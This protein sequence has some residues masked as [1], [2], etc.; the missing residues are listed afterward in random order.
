MVIRLLRSVLPLLFFVLMAFVSENTVAQ[1]R[2]PVLEYATG[3]WCQYCPCGHEI[4]NN[5]ILPNYPNAVILGYHGPVGY[6]DPFAGFDGYQMM[7]TL[8]FSSY[9]SGIIDRTSA[10]VSRT[11]WLSRVAGRNSIPATV[12]ISYQKSWNASSRLFSVTVNVNPLST[13]N[14]EYKL[15]AVLTEDNLVATQ[16]GN[17]GCPGGTNYRHNHVARAIMNGAN[18]TILNETSPW[19]PG[20][21]VTKT[22][23]YTLDSDFDEEHC[24]V[25]VFVYKNTSPLATAEIQQAVQFE[26]LGGA[27]YNIFVN[28]GWNMI[29]VPNETADMTVSSLF[30]SSSSNAFAFN[31]GYVQVDELDNGIGYWLKFNGQEGFDIQGAA[32]TG[33]IQLN[34]GWNL[35]GPYN[36]N[37]ATEGITTNPSGIITSQFFEFNGAYAT[38]SLLQ[39]GKGYWVKTSASGTMSYTTLAKKGANSFETPTVSEDWGIITITDAAGNMTRLYAA[40]G[41]T[42]VEMFELPPAPPAEVFD[43]RFSSGSYVETFETPREIVFNAVQYPVVISV[44]NT[45]LELKDITGGS[46]V[47]TTLSDGNEIV[48]SNESVNRLSV[49]SVSLPSGYVLEQNYP[50][51][52]NPTTTIKFAVSEKANVNLSVFNLLGQKVTE[53][54]NGE[55]EAG[56]HEAEFKADNLSS[57]VYIYTLKVNEF[58]TSRKMTILK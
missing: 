46:F 48:I 22:V 52:F 55:V 12:D 24:H 19:T 30:P 56:S 31:N 32:P 51:P 42:N 21:T 4:I 41:G 40:N 9:P 17:S 44:N 38:S 18:G 35:V 54:V 10:P 8:G 5:N 50:N 33:D 13:M 49:N 27:S 25:A 15:L 58:T 11:Q 20:T 53:I 34:E 14:D 2:N 28:E 37:V 43:A 6:G 3:T 45:T 7:S 23:T 29:S 57:G 39:V 16:S 26:L 36:V 1:Q 47:N